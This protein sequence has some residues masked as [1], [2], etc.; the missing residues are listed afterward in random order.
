VLAATRAGRKKNPSTEYTDDRDAK[1][2]RRSSLWRQD[3]GLGTLK[4]LYG[5]LT[6]LDSV[7]NQSGFAA[8]TKL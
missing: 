2:R 4:E 1:K 6:R 5:Q 8:I 7:D 3:A